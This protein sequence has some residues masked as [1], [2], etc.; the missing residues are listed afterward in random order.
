MTLKTGSYNPKVY[1]F[2]GH[3]CDFDRYIDHHDE[4]IEAL[5]SSCTRQYKKKTKPLM[6][7]ARSN[8]QH[9]WNERTAP[10]PW[11]YHDGGS[12]SY[13]QGFI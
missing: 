5:S 1:T 8:T 10:Y 2:D 7:Y 9:W 12:W 3:L 6:K 13:C 11:C 4:Y